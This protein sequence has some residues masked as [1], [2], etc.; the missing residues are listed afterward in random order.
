MDE[1]DLVRSSNKMKPTIIVC[2][3][4]RYKNYREEYLVQLG[5]SGELHE[6]STL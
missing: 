5:R 2:Y 1:N 3:N 4:R 6:G